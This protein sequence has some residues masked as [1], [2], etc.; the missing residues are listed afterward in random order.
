MYTDSTI[1]LITMFARFRI[2]SSSCTILCIVSKLA[3]QRF[4]RSFFLSKNKHLNY[5]QSSVSK[6]KRNWDVV[7]LKIQSFFLA[8]Q[9]NKRVAACL[10]NLKL[11]FLASLL[12]PK[13]THLYRYLYNIIHVVITV[14]SRELLTRARLLAYIRVCGRARH[15]FLH[16]SVYA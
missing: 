8:W 16:I 5:Q 11:G 12:Y 7:R 2:T 10:G 4:G 1:F 13:K 9:L 14:L 3:I 6:I 15:F